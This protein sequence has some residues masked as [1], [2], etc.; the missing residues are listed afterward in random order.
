M[1]LHRSI[2]IV[3]HILPVGIA[4]TH[5]FKDVV[6]IGFTLIRSCFFHQGSVLS[7]VEELA[8]AP[9]ILPSDGEIILHHWLADATTLGCYEYNTICSTSTINGT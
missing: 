7:S 5:T 1:I 3:E 8:F 9:R 4:V 6:Y 2:V